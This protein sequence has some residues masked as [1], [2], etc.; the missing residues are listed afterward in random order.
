MTEQIVDFFMYA[1][2]RQLMHLS[3]VR[4]TLRPPGKGTSM[5]VMCVRHSHPL[6]HWRTIEC[7]WRTN[8]KSFVGPLP[9][10]ERCTLTLMHPSQ[11]HVPWQTK[12]VILTHTCSTFYQEMTHPWRT[13]H[14]ACRVRLTF[15]KCIKGLMCNSIYSLPLKLEGN[16]FESYIFI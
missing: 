14:G 6:R 12:A 2:G 4:R 9:D 13:S 1:M 10:I 15:D 8:I 3:I 11:L 16:I 7:V 5:F